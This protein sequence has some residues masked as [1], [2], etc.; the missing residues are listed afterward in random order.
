MTT[1]T[2]KSLNSKPRA[3]KAAPAP[4]SAAEST[5]AAPASPAPTT[6]PLITDTER[7][8]IFELLTP[9]QQEIAGALV[10]VLLWQQQRE[11]AEAMRASLLEERRQRVAAAR[12]LARGNALDTVEQMSLHLIG[13][14]AVGHYLTRSML[15]FGGLEGLYLTISE[16][17]REALRQVDTT[18]LETIAE[19]ER[20]EIEIA[21]DARSMVDD[22]G[23][24][25]RDRID[26]DDYADESDDDDGDAA[27]E[28]T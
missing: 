16:G 18:E 26:D 20:A 17:I 13:K 10:D 25:R 1:K 28:S 15:D 9:E 11:E 8:E 23:K 5:T 2:T 6:A 14:L 4:E 12:E 21:A 27:A 22:D 19:G 3:A 7:M 24:L